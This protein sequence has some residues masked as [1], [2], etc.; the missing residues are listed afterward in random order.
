MEKQ[1]Q[2]AKSGPSGLKEKQALSG[3]R[4]EHMLYEF[5]GLGTEISRAIKARA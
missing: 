4:Q 3:T 5:Y 1:I 2:L